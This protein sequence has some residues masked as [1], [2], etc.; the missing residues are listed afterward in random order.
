MITE[1]ENVTESVVVRIFCSTS[2]TKKVMGES[3]SKQV[4]RTLLLS[5]FRQTSSP[6][7][8]LMPLV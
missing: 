6:A 5:M 8:K 1:L 4:S 3:V 7:P 2:K